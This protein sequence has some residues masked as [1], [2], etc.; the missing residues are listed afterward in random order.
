MRQTSLTETKKML[1]ITFIACLLAY[2]LIMIFLHLLS[3]NLDAL[4]LAIPY[5]LA[6][7]VPLF[8]LFAVVYNFLAARIQT[9]INDDRRDE[10][11]VGYAQRFPVLSSVMVAAPLLAA[12]VGIGFLFRGL[13][14]LVTAFQIFYF[15]TLGAILSLCITLFNYYRVKIIL[16]P[17]LSA[18]N[19]NSLTIFEKLLA[20]ILSFMLVTLLFLGSLIY[21]LNVNRTIEFY[22]QKTMFESEKTAL[23]IDNY[24]NSIAL[25]LKSTLAFMNPDDMSQRESDREAIRIF[26][27]RQNEHIETLFIARTDGDTSSNRGAHANL[28]D[29][30]YF[31]ESAKTLKMAW[32]DILTS[33]DTGNKVIVCFVPKVAGGAMRGGLGVTINFKAIGSLINDIS[34]S[35]ETKYHVVNR[36]GKIIY[37]PD[38]KYIDKVLGKDLVDDNGKDLAAFLKNDKGEFQRYKINGE[39][40]TLR[41]TTLRSTGHSLVSAT[42]ESVMMKPINMIIV[43]LGMG[44]LIVIAAIMAILYR[45]GRGFSNP[46]KNTIAIFGRLAA[47]DLTARSDDYLPDEFGDMIKNMKR[48]QDKIHEVVDSALNSSNQL[49]ASAEELSATSSS[50]AESAQSQAASVEEA[51]ASLE[52]ISAS[53]ES[54]AGSSKAQSDHAKN[55]Y[56]LIEELGKLIKAVNS[57]SIATLNVANDTT[58]E[59]MKGNEIMQNTISGMNSIEDNSLKIAEMV[60][61]IS[62]ISDQVNLLA[63]NAAIEAA[64]AGEHGRGFAVVADEIGKLAE[65]TAL[66]AKNITTL[67]SNGVRSAKQ[68]IQDVNETSR[69]LENIINY[70]NKT[71]Q[72]VQ[73]IAQSTEVQARAGEDVIVATKQVMEMAD[74]ISSS[75]QEQTITHNEISKTMT[76]INTQ[77]QSQAS[78]AEEIA[79][80][81]EEISAQAESMKTLLEFFKIDGSLGK[82]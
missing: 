65:Q 54:I 48:F 41:K 8:L 30:G 15:I 70:I 63:L 56:N 16:Y 67:V 24:F 47:G 22:K 12:S 77:T 82:G 5:E 51:T 34:S 78:G 40:M 79:S 52:E 50:L 17:V 11:T 35:E 21:S 4:R 53:N 14:I 20:P 33:R 46:I 39:P 18:N 32:S 2:P 57:D 68:G 26:N 1:M 31:I 64:R 44:V 72:L 74:S 36:D 19:L 9:M 13:E 25:E 59:A 75:T 6:L 81:A 37:H 80:S 69:A 71:K 55:T 43:R 49:A 60:S 38:P 27:N 66:S 28:K 76:Q 45:I 7:F 29:R 10:V 23:S 3:L 62:D 58:S 73:K 42:F 61:L